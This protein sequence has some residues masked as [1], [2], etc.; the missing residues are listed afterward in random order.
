[1]SIEKEKEAMVQLPEKQFKTIMDRLAA[2][3]KGDGTSKKPKLVTEHTATL[4]EWQDELVIGVKKVYQLFNTAS[5]KMEDKVDLI[6][7]EG[8]KKKI[9]TADYLDY[10]NNGNKVKVKILEQKSE[11]VVIT[12][13]TVN[14]VDAKD[15]RVFSD[16]QIDLNVTIVEA[17]AKVE[18]LEGNFK[19]EIFKISNK[20]LND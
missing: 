11:P 16:Q 12:E 7:K 13:N 18:V 10:L 8:D 20:S 4:R 17:V 3:E 6:I 2:L 1:M 15:D 19:G 9:V 14:L 5:Q